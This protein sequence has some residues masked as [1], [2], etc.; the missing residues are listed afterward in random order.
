MF[1]PILIPVHVCV[2]EDISFSEH[3]VLCFNA[4]SDSA[5]ELNHILS[6]WI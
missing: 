1:I 6:N 5:D 2:S 4:L 3:M